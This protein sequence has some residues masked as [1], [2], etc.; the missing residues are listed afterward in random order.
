MKYRLGSSLLILV[1]LVLAGCS[2]TEESKVFAQEGEIGPTLDEELPPNLPLG[3]ESYEIEEERGEGWIVFSSD[4]DGDYE[5]YRMNPDG[6]ETIQLTENDRTDWVYHGSEQILF[7]SD[8]LG[9]HPG[10]QIDLF[11][12]NADGS[13][14]KKIN[15]FPILDSY[16]STDPEENRFLVSSNLDGDSEIYVIDKEGAVLGQLTDNEF[17]D[18]DPFWSPGGYRV[19]F[20]S[21]RSGSWEIWLV[22]LDGSGLRQLTDSPN[23]D[24]MEGYQ[25]GP[26][27]WS[28]DGSRILFSS[29]RDGD[30]DIYVVRPDGW[31][32]QNLTDNEFADIWAAWS[33]DGKKIVF[34]SDRDGNF[35]I[36]VM[37]ADGTGELRLS[38]HPESDQTPVW[39]Q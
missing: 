21:N 4:R 24:E 27:R 34:D 20:R 16:V 6:S 31:D 3:P 30:F 33:P 38:D 29:E 14:Q 17:E 35:E 23:N 11:Q 26:P 15:D 1:L 39:I 10:G 32:L 19:A 25:E 9:N 5:V 36:Y 28:P 22:N 8:R 2:E 37:N 12:M 18:R 13:T 7:G